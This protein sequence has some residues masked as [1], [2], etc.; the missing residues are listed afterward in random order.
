MAIKVSQAFQRTSANPVDETMALTKAQMLAVDDNLMPN[1]YFTVCQDDGA[2]YL[3]DKSATASAET[4]KFAKFEPKGDTGVDITKEAFDQLTPAEKN[5]GT[6]YYIPDAT[7][8]SGMMVVGNRFDKANIYTETERMIGSWMGKPLYQKTFTGTLSN[9]NYTD[10]PDIPSD[11]EQ[12]IHADGFVYKS[13]ADSTQIGSYLNSGYYAGFYGLGELWYSDNYKGGTYLVTVQYTKSTDGQIAI[14]TENDYSTDEVIIGTWI[15]SKPLYQKTLSIINKSLSSGDNTIIDDPSF[16][17]IST[18]ISISL[19]NHSPNHNTYHDV[20]RMY[21]NATWTGGIN[22]I[23]TSNGL[24]IVYN[25][26]SNYA[27][28]G[29]FNIYVTVQYT[30]TT[31]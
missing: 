19:I 16:P 25:I 9:N 26:G 10:I 23:S 15:D 1:K 20:V 8:T 22:Y 28:E 2:L 13:A 12:V 27:N 6:T 18:L 3:Y 14:G 7:V 11:I 5:N 24:T 29:P 4:G 17:S 21:P 31:D 30:K